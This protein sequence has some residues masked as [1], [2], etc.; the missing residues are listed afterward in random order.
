MY[1]F[2]KTLMSANKSS[3]LDHKGTSRIRMRKKYHD[4]GKFPR[5]YVRASTFSEY[6]MSVCS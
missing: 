1:Q 3:A 2:V 4:G 6:E 5:V